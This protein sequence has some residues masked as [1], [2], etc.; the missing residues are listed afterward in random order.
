MK[1]L[2]VKKFEDDDSTQTLKILTG[3]AVEGTIV[4]E[5]LSIDKESGDTIV[6]FTLETPSIEDQVYRTLEELAAE[7]DE[8]SVEAPVLTLDEDAELLDEITFDDPASDALELSLT[9][10]D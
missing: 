6:H 8:E 2:N 4:T 10:N 3:E 5:Q 7:I 9:E 1:V